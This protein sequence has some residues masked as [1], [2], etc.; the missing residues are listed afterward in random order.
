MATKRK[1]GGGKPKTRVVYRTRPAAP[2]KRRRPRRNPPLLDG[3]LIKEALAGVAGFVVTKYAGRILSAASGQMPFLQSP[4]GKALT[5]GAVAVGLGMLAGKVVPGTRGAVTVGGVTA[6][7]VGF[8]ARAGVP[9]LSGLGAAEVNL[10]NRDL[11]EIAATADMLKRK[12]LAAAAPMEGVGEY[13]F[14]EYG[15][16][17]YE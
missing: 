2:T 13:T 4:A 5:E 17:T 16:V 12:Q 10:S 9:G 15:E 11:A 6:A 3:G 8:L 7:S 14:T 1:T